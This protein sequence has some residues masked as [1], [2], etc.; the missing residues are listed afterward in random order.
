M[1]VCVGYG[2]AAVLEFKAS[3]FFPNPEEIDEVSGDLSNLLLKSF[4]D[5]I[6]THR[7]MLLFHMEL[8][9]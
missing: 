9:L 6:P 2:I 5:F 8:R 7:M 4:K 1:S 3:L